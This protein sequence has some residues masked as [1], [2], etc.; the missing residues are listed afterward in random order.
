[1]GRAWMDGDELLNT[2]PQTPEVYDPQASMAKAFLAYLVTA[3][4]ILL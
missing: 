2:E 1:M 3:G 4:H